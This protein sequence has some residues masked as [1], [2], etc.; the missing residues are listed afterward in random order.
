MPTPN[1]R[2]LREIQCATTI[3]ENNYMLVEFILHFIL[4]N[5]L[6]SLKNTVYMSS[7]SKLRYPTKLIKFG[8]VGYGGLRFRNMGSEVEEHVTKKYDI[9]KRLGKGVRK[10]L[11]CSTV[12]ILRY[13]TII[14]RWNVG[15]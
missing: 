9:K 13:S 1:S 15:I 5:V 6:L 7:P 8:N 2:T 12:I 11:Y 14:Q 3:N 4:H 10:S